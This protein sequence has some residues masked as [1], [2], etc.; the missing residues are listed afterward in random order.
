MRPRTTIRPGRLP[1]GEDSVR[2]ADPHTAPA[3][4][5]NSQDPDE[6][7]ADWLT[8]TDMLFCKLEG[9]SLLDGHASLL[10][11]PDLL[12]RQ[13]PCP[14]LKG[15]P[16]LEPTPYHHKLPACQSSGTCTKKV[17]LCRTDGQGSEDHEQTCIKAKSAIAMV[18]P[19]T[20]NLYLLKFNFLIYKMK[21]ITP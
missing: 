2:N 8:F 18:V 4:P 12:R 15:R 1:G 20:R 14:T 6:D 9:T 17:L 7:S 5:R 21:V 3:S 19:W 11:S 16:G 10:L 13:V